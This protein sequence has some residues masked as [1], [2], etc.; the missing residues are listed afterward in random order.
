LAGR[1]AE[2]EWDSWS[3]AD[4]HSVVEEQRRAGAEQDARIDAAA[5][6]QA[7][8]SRRAHAALDSAITAAA[9]ELHQRIRPHID[10]IGTPTTT[11]RRTAVER[12]MDSLDDYLDR[13]IGRE[14]QSD[15]IYEP[16]PRSWW[17]IAM[18]LH[19]LDEPDVVRYQGPVIR[20]YHSPAG[21]WEPL[22]GSKVDGVWTGS[23]RRDL[24]H[25]DGFNN[26]FWDQRIGGLYVATRASR[27]VSQD[28]LYGDT[29]EVPLLTAFAGAVAAKV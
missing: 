11:R 10:R 4:F 13:R 25:W 3:P 26:I 17:D 15:W 22:S 2:Q 5:D 9:I 8:E 12:L 6:A 19:P 27:I 14:P 1:A 24:V 23:Q 16:K 18:P 21:K 20:I 29:L 28:L 7:A